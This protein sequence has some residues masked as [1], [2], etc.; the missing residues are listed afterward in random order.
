M[1][2]NEQIE[3]FITNGY[4][5]VKQAF[6]RELADRC[7][8]IFWA[9]TGYDPDDRSTWKKSVIR[10]PDHSEPPFVQ[11]ANTRKLRT[12]FD[13]L[14]GQGRWQPR[15]SSG[16]CIV[17]FPIGEGPGDTGWHIDSSFPGKDSD[18]NDYS[19]WRINI[20]SRDRSLLMLF[21]F[22]DVGEQDAPTRIRSGSHL[23][24][25]RILAPAGE[26]GLTNFDVSV[27]ANCP[28]VIATGAAGT[29]YLCHPFLVH[30]AQINRGSQ[31]RFMT[32]P[33]LFP[34]GSFGCAG[35]KPSPI[36]CVGKGTSSIPIEEAVCRALS[37]SNLGAARQPS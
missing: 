20:H 2:T 29:I 15:F 26:E 17:R 19:T 28:E 27:T 30:A 33:P 36:E 25:A 21:L 8:K 16:Y 13:Q 23:E 34:V 7:C 35:K 6:A 10:T 31:P 9:D 22:S 12:A 37:K 5:R 1:L 4:V 32:Q 11:A 3:R 24:V 18:P 14:V